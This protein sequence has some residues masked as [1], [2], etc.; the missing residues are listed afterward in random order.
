MHWWWRLP[1]QDIGVLTA[2]P[3]VPDIPRHNRASA[4]LR[5]LMLGGRARGVQ[6][7]A[8]SDGHPWHA[9]LLLF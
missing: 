6:A 5:A 7:K 9:T 1:D 2:L 8:A 3:P 4:V